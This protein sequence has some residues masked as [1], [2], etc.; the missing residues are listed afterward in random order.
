MER[1]GAG[2][3]RRPADAAVA[4]GG[5]REKARRLLGGGLLPIF[6]E[7]RFR[8]P[9]AYDSLPIHEFTPVSIPWVSPLVYGFR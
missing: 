9:I 2:D 6:G 7:W 5:A 4:D 3:R 8:Q 1:D